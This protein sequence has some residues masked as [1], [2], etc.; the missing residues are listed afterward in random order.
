MRRRALGTPSQAATIVAAV[1]AVAAAVRV[2]MEVASVVGARATV[3]V[4]VEVFT[5]TPGTK[6]G[7]LSTTGD[8]DFVA[9]DEGFR[10][11]LLFFL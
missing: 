5:L 7:S 3:R 10:K 8:A 2:V 11:L 1:V 6:R 9:V 4:P